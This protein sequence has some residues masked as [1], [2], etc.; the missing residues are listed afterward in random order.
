MDVH[1][2]FVFKKFRSRDVARAV[3]Y[4][5]C[6]QFPGPWTVRL[7][8]PCTGARDM[9]REVIAACIDADVADAM[10]DHDFNRWHVLHFTVPPTPSANATSTPST[11]AS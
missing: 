2:F 7:V 11:P 10:S 9:W 4:A 3:I 1:E 6:S 8:E 5:L